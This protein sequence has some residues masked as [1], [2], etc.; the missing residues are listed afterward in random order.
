MCIVPEMSQDP[1]RIFRWIQILT[2]TR[3]I[4]NVVLFQLI[5]FIIALFHFRL[6]FTYTSPEFRENAL[7]PAKI[8]EH[9]IQYPRWFLSIF[10]VFKTFHQRNNLSYTTL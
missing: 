10:M 2:K 5:A 1:N 9:W 7:D 6:S 4:H 3:K 8:P